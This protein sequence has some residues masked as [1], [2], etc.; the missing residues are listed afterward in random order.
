MSCV[1]IRSDDLKCGSSRALESVQLVRQKDPP[2]CVWLN[3]LPSSRCWKSGSKYMEWLSY[4]K[5]PF[6]VANVHQC[7]EN[8]CTGKSCSWI[9]AALYPTQIAHKPH[10]N[11]N[12]SLKMTAW[13]RLCEAKSHRVSHVKCLCIPMFVHI[14]NNC[15]ICNAVLSVYMCQT[16]FMG[17]ADSEHCIQAALELKPC[18][19]AEQLHTSRGFR[20]KSWTTAHKP[21]WLSYTTQRHVEWPGIH[22]TSEQ[23]RILSLDSVSSEWGLLIFKKKKAQMPQNTQYAYGCDNQKQK[24]MHWP[25]KEIEPMALEWGLCDYVIVHTI[26][27]GSPVILWISLGGKPKW[28]PLKFGYHDVIHTSPICAPTLEMIWG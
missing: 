15:Y 28:L 7:T 25:Q 23:Q 8:S 22:S 18:Q 4:R 13:C 2:P 20:T 19:K 27:G 17:F 11:K 6:W 9:Q 10:S 12:C 16:T 14:W 21:P 5:V 3:A 26:L 1:N 24:K